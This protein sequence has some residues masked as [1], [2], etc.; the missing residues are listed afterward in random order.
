MVEA[1]GRRLHV[2]AGAQ[3]LLGALP[4]QSICRVRLLCVVQVGQ[5]VWRQSAACLGHAHTMIE[6]VVNAWV[7]CRSRTLWSGA[8]LSGQVSGLNERSLTR[9]LDRVELGARRALTL[10]TDAR[11]SHLSASV[12]R[13]IHI[14]AA[15]AGSTA[16]L[17]SLLLLKQELL[18]AHKHRLLDDN[19]R[20]L[21]DLI[22]G[23]GRSLRR[24]RRLD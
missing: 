5:L 4:P 12:A 21:L 2:V 1:A 17:A 16:R 19:D 22:A 15:L 8:F 11:K 23:R 6:E 18:S 10:L 24:Q 3:A 20:L 7:R 14:S 13:H 9:F